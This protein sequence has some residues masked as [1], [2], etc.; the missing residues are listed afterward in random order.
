MSYSVKWELGGIDAQTPEEAVLQAI[1]IVTDPCSVATCWFVQ[2]DASNKSG[3]V[4]MEDPADPLWLRE[5]S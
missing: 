5:F 4:D 2:D 1:A 3:V